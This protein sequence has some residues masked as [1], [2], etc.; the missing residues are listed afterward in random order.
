MRA[1]VAPDYPREWFRCPYCGD[2]RAIGFAAC[3]SHSDLPA[4][5]DDLRLALLLRIE[6]RAVERMAKFA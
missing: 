4:L 1:H 5:E 2:P 3:P 6:T